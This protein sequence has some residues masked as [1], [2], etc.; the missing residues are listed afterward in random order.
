MTL[1][2]IADENI[3]GVERYFQRGTHIEKVNGRTLESAQVKNADVLLVRSVTAVN[4]ALLEGSS[5]RF[6]GTATSGVEHVDEAWLQSQGIGFAHA[7]GANANSVVEY[8]LAAIGGCENRLERLMQGET[9]G[10]I[11]YGVIGRQVV[12]CFRALGIECCVY[13]PWLP[14]SDIHN[15]VTLTQILDCEVITLHCELTKQQPWPSLHLLAETELAVLNSGQLLINACR[16]AVIDN[17]ALLARLQQQDAPLV[18]LDVWENEPA[19]SRELVDLVE[20]G[21]AHI[22][23]YSLDGKLLATRMLAEAAADSLNVGLGDDSGRGAGDLVEP[24]QPLRIMDHWQGAELIRELIQQRYDIRRDDA[25]LRNALSSV[26]MRA[27]SFSGVTEEASEHVVTFDS[28]RKNYA[29]RRELRGSHLFA[30][31]L[32]DS[33]RQIVTALGCSFGAS[34]EKLHIGLIINPLAGLGGSRGFKGSD[35]EEVRKLAHNARPDQLQRAHDRVVRALE[36]LNEHSVHITTWSGSMGESALDKVSLGSTV[37][38][39]PGSPST[40]QLSTADDTRIAALALKDH[41]V[42]LLVFAGGDGTAR[43][44]YDAVGESLPVLGIPAGVKMHSGV[45]AVSPEAAGELLNELATGGLVGLTLREVRDIDEAAFREDI[46]RSR[47]YGDLQVPGEGRYLQHTKVGGRE[48]KELVAAEIASWIVEQLVPGTLY[49]IGPG[50]TT[51][52]IMLELGLENTLLGVD[53]IK[54]GVL[55]A[56]DVDESRLLHAL[57]QHS[58]P[59]QIIVTAIGGQGHIFGRGNQQFSPQV[60]RRVGLENISIVAAKSKITSLQ[61]RPL[62][63]DTDDP[64][65]DIQL[66]GYHIVTTGYDDSVFYR[67]ATKDSGASPQGEHSNE[68]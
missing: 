59:A 52:A 38:G 28:L 45:F 29:P 34:A 32:E 18:V 66:C 21:T 24:P 23:G 2:I 30:T 67:I 68:Q 25:L 47:F 41:G 61:G 11:G 26:V 3:P 5:V 22:A 6:V 8:V 64:K 17:R 46:V 37:L 13:D 65:L 33:Q 36:L 49:L 20:W 48:S 51:A 10:V 43:D 44:I 15:P 14:I 31:A 19:I 63:V 62:L 42:D 27:G 12:Q 40:S 4:E 56:S 16:G 9:V 39:G 54:D 57:E 55:I 58:G 7:P 53:V 60:L 50:S 35:S 1:H